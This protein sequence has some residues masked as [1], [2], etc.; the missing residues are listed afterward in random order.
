MCC[1]IG[2]NMNKTSFASD[3]IPCKHF[4]SNTCN[5]LTKEQKEELLFRYHKEKECNFDLPAH[6]EGN[7]YYPVRKPTWMYSCNCPYDEEDPF[8]QKL[9]ML[10]VFCNFVCRCTTMSTCKLCKS[11]LTIHE[12]DIYEKEHDKWTN[13]FKAMSCVRNNSE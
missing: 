3:F 2:N 5:C 1:Q 10:S 13:C 9:Q 6:F 8:I 4:S 7:G 11:V 12:T